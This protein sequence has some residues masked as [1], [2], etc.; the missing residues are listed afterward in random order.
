MYVHKKI[1]TGK[2]SELEVSHAL[3]RTPV[4]IRALRME[5][6]MDENR[7]IS[8]GGPGNKGILGRGRKARGPVLEGRGVQESR[9]TEARARSQKVLPGGEEKFT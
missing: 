6:L 7:Q 8:P 5:V 9:E 2:D 3:P 1:S 4:I